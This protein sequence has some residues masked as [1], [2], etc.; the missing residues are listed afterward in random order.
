[1]DLNLE[2]ACGSVL[3]TSDAAHKIVNVIAVVRRVVASRLKKYKVY[4]RY[5]IYSSS[6]QPT[7][8]AHTLP[9]YLHPLADAV[10]GVGTGMMATCLPA[11]AAIDVPP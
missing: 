1:V 4:I 7:P 8:M 5:H 6:S 2:E 11:P 3:G 10:V 9:R